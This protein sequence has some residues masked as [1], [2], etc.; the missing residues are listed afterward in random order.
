MEQEFLENKPCLNSY[1]GSKSYKITSLKKDFLLYTPKHFPKNN[2]FSLTRKIPKSRF[3]RPP[4]PY[5]LFKNNS[6]LK[7]YTLLGI[8]S[9]QGDS[10]TIFWKLFLRLKKKNAIIAYSP[11]L[12]NP[13]F[14]YTQQADF[15][16]GIVWIKTQLCCANF[17]SFC[18][19]LERI[20]GRKRKREFKNAPRTLDLDILGFKNKTIRFKHLCI[21]HKEWANRPSVTIP[22]KGFL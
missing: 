14:G 17:F 9:N 12:K 2:A 15:Y 18:F 21:P 10:L 3:I 13:A 8:G 5:D 6:K 7:S 1:F 20:F 11:F 19:Y 22:L 4:S 16:N